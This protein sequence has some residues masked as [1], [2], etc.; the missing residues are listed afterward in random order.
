MKY[1]GSLEMGFSEKGE[2]KEAKRTS[3]E[4]RL[5]PRVVRSMPEAKVLRSRFCTFSTCKSPRRGK[6]RDNPTM[7]SSEEANQAGRKGRDHPQGQKGS[8]RQ[9]CQAWI[10]RSLVVF[11]L[12]S[13]LPGWIE[14]GPDLMLDHLGS[15]EQTRP[16]TGSLAAKHACRNH[17]AKRTVRQKPPIARLL[18]D[19]ADLHRMIHER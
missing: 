6:V 9:S 13:E 2:A 4:E 10:D 12:S 3:E 11:D 16:E 7:F 5:R 14:R 15:Q 8:W 1:S 17:I 18:P 19:Q